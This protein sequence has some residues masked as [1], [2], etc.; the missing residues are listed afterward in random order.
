[1]NFGLDHDGTFDADPALWGAWIVLARDL[2]HTVYLVTMR[3]E[4]ELY[5]DPTDRFHPVHPLIAELGVP[6]I[7]TNRAAKDAA[8]RAQGV[9]INVWIDDNPQAVHNHATVIWPHPFPQG[10]TQFEKEP[11]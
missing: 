4:D 8:C 6:I 2:G 7:A 1:M 5:G 3:G 10:Q 9:V 11:S